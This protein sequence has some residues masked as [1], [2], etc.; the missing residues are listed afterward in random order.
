MEETETPL[1]PLQGV[2]WRPER[3]DTW[4]QPFH[5]AS[6]LSIRINLIF[7]ALALSF[8]SWPAFSIDTSAEEQTCREIGFKPKTEK[9][10]NCVLDLYER[11]GVKATTNSAVSTKPVQAVVLGDGSQDDRTCQNY[12]FKPGQEG[13]SNCRM[14]IDMAKKEAQVAQARYQRELAAYEEQAAELKRRQD[15]ERS[16]RLMELGLRMMG[17]QPPIEAANSIGTGAP[18]SKPTPPSTFQSIRLPNGRIMNCSTT[19]TYTNCN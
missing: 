12:G 9:F 5:G 16:R 8:V 1:A 4:C 13:Y 11:R 15:N 3:T 7:F 6:C 14:Q 10:A 2:E 18:I 17:G 19:G